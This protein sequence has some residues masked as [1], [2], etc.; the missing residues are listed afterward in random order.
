MD[1]M[2]L[3]LRPR[4]EAFS[5]DE[6]NPNTLL[7]VDKFN[8][9]DPHYTY[10]KKELVTGDEVSFQ[11]DDENGVELIEEQYNAGVESGRIVGPD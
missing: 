10:T 4:D 7:L 1:I 11:G 3:I 9:I 5:E 6:V 8:T 2:G